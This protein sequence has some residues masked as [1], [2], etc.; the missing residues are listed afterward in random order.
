M[1]KHFS[2]LLILRGRP[3][4][5]LGAVHKRRPH[6]IAKKLPPLRLSEKCSHWLNPTCPCRVHMHQ[7]FRS[8]HQ[9]LLM[10]A[11]EE[12]PIVRTGQPILSPDCGL[13]NR[14]PL[15]LKCSDCIHTLIE[16]KKKYITLSSE[17][18]QHVSSLLKMLKL[19]ELIRQN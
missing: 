9:K 11:S 2:Y 10:S 14:Q 15:L 8:L 18:M 13:L 4:L 3:C 19:K 5:F 12:L 7:K 16:I 6:K 1:F 17:I